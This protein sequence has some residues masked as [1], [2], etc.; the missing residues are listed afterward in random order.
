MCYSSGMADKTPERN[1][2]DLIA[3]KQ[4]EASVSE[5]FA[6]NKHVL[7]FGSPGQ[8]VIMA[9]KEGV[10][11]SL[12]ACEEAGILPDVKVRLSEES[13][14]MI[15]SILDN[16]PGI[17]K[18]NITNVF[19]KLLFGS[20]FDSW[21]ASR[22]AQGLG[23]SAAG[24]YGYITTNKPMT[25]Y[26]K[27]KGRE[28][29][30]FA[31]HI[32]TKTNSAK[33]VKEM[34]CD[35]KLFPSGSGTFVSIPMEGTYQRGKRG[36]DGYIEATAFS[37]PHASLYFINPKRE[38]MKIDRVTNVIPPKPKKMKPYPTG[39]DYQKFI[40]TVK[41][42]K[43][44]SIRLILS[45][46][47]SNITMPVI[48]FLLDGN[49]KL[50]SV[51]GS[52]LLENET[53]LKQIFFKMSF[54]CVGRLTHHT[55]VESVL[56]KLPKSKLTVKEFLIANYEGI[57]IEKAEVLLGNNANVK[58]SMVKQEEIKKLHTALT[59]K[60]FP[61]S[62]PSMESLAPIGTNA[63][64]ARL[65]QKGA[66][67]VIVNTLEGLVVKG[68]PMMIEIGIGFEGKIDIDG[69]SPVMRFA[70]RVP[71]LHAA[72]ACAI[73]DAIT[74]IDW[75]SCGLQHKVGEMPVG[76]MIFVIHISSLWLPFTDQAKVAISH[77]P[78]I[79]KYL[80]KGLM[81]CKRGIE[82]YMIDKNREKERAMKLAMLGAYS[83]ELKISISAILGKD[84]KGFD[85]AL[86][87][88]CEAEK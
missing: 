87:Q 84:V 59:N 46:N 37:N 28:G 50:A 86:M 47:F 63:I 29:V 24:M 23:I 31:F 41:T 73:T 17:V 56:R 48:N 1:A 39:I 27:V 55:N 40:E 11:N 74:S 62:A 16:G 4:R 30:G 36:V 35:D 13:G 43:N 68:S 57:P 14:D 2:A 70:N 8:A 42:H 79:V 53:I 26:S 83:K 64:K 58:I 80:K 75:S 77:D 6:K 33:I 22:G 10:D 67:S 66:E 54:L 3:D 88:L 76:S 38:I 34:I 61:I 81:E 20:K 19:C 7:G 12:D 82:N 72:K 32:D 71:L 69:A 51:K 21:T 18:E 9:V 85:A 45:N 65:K 60:F 49:Q 5:F 52:E 44:D 25:V 15:V 78:S